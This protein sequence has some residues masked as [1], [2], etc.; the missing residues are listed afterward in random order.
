MMDQISDDLDIEMNYTTTVDHVPEAERNNCTLKERIRAIYYH[1]LPYKAM[2]PKLML[3]Y[4]STSSAAQLNFFPA[5]TGVSAY[6]SPHAIMTQRNLD[7]N[8]HK[9]PYNTNAPCTMDCIY[10]GPSPNIQGGHILM[11][12]ASGQC[13]SRP[14]MTA[15]PVTTLV[16]KVVAA[17]AARQGIKSLKL[18][19]KFYHG[20]AHTD[21]EGADSDD[22]DDDS[23]SS[24]SSGSN[25][26][27]NSSDTD[28]SGDD[29]DDDDIDD[30]SNYNQADASELDDLAAKS[31]NS[32]VIPEP[33]SPATLDSPTVS[34]VDHEDSD[35]ILRKDTRDPVRRSS[36]DTTHPNKYT[37]ARLQE[38]QGKEHGDQRSAD[39]LSN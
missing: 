29:N 32:S 1:M 13:I 36:R 23:T 35:S 5:K 33:A 21:L 31:D 22:S 9:V 15:I 19:R 28:D 16:I 7:Y 30:E 11:D 24:S 38:C 10:L 34:T 17:M 4:L 20:H 14:R 18:T 37:H 8:H 6:F 25:S 2:I 27:D 39:G 26:N 3:S 12:M